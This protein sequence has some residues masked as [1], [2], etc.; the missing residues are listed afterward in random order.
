MRVIERVRKAE[1]KCMRGGERKMKISE[2]QGERTS[3]G[4]KENG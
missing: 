2:M 4:E 1:R 3:V